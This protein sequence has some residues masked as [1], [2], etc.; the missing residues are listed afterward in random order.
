MYDEGE[1][2]GERDGPQEREGSAREVGKEGIRAPD[3]GVG[4]A[5]RQT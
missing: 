4:Q 3:A 5:G 1:Q 2:S